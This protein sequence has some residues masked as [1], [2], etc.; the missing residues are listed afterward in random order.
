MLDVVERE[1]FFVVKKTHTH[2]CTCLWYVN[3]VL[4]PG[5]V[6]MSSRHLMRIENQMEMMIETGEDTESEGSERTAISTALKSSGEKVSTAFTKKTK[7]LK[8][9][10]TNSLCQ[11][12]FL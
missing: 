7:S 2:I 4:T 8:V 5:C 10:R 6:F 12:H 9:S 11:Q 1:Y 3:V